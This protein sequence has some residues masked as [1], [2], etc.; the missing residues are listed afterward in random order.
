MKRNELIKNIMT[1]NI[2]SVSLMDDLFVAKQKMENLGVQH[3]PV[4]EG[5]KLKGIISRID[6][7]KYFDSKAYNHIDETDSADVLECGL[8]A[9]Q[10]MTKNITVLSEN[11]T[12]REASEILTTSSFNS[13]PIVNSEHELVGLITTKDL[14]GYLLEQY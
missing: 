5:S 2:V 14:L 13:L 11:N 1:T 7:L 6:V 8:T 10:V 4:V 12:V 9:E 3:I